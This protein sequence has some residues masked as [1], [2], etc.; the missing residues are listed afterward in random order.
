M[1]FEMEEFV[2]EVFWPDI[3]GTEHEVTYQIQLVDEW[4]DS[5]LEP[6]GQEWEFVDGSECID[7]SEQ[8]VMLWMPN[9]WLEKICR[10]NF[11]ANY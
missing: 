6:A 5:D 2:T 10:K 3:A 9:G 8:T 11:T 1:G 4:P 7:E